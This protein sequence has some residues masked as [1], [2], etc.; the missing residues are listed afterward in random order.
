MSDTFKAFVVKEKGYIGWERGN[1]FNLSIF[2][3]ILCNVKLIGVDR[4]TAKQN[5]AK[6]WE[7]LADE[8]K[9][10]I[11]KDIVTEIGMQQLKK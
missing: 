9:P 11:L 8:W 7:L 6:I 2:P 5:K 1:A 4:A 3:F 10:T